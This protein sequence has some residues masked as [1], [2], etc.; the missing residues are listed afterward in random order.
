M[1]S[2]RKPGCSKAAVP[3]FDGYCCLV[4]KVNAGA[5]VAAAPVSNTPPKP[6]P[7]PKP[8]EKNSSFVACLT[9]DALEN[10]TSFSK[11]PQKQ[12]PAQESKFAN[13][14]SGH[15]DQ[16]GNSKLQKAGQPQSQLVDRL[17][18]RLCCP[19]EEFEAS[20][21]MWPGKPW[22]PVTL[23]EA[24]KRARVDKVDLSMALCVGHLFKSLL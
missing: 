2:C 19:A 8:R 5:V 10:G 22:Q 1:M 9:M 4:H 23:V 24:I 18:D 20:S 14:T 16:L 17:R 3:S 12:V 15:L 21:P 13:F 7:P 11:K 6:A